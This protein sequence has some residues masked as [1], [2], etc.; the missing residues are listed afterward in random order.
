MRN[1]RIVPTLIVAAVATVV[2]AVYLLILRAHELAN[3]ARWHLWYRH[4][5]LLLLFWRLCLYAAT[6][7]GWVILRRRRGETGLSREAQIRLTKTEIAA[8][9]ALISVEAASLYAQ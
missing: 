5:W 6:I 2:V 3:P 4:A 8:L 9:L 1:D 7:Y